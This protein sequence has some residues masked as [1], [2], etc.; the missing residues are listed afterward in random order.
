ML[1]SH[2]LLYPILRATSATWS[3]SICPDLVEAFSNANWIGLC[4]SDV[5]KSPVGVECTGGAEGI[6]QWFQ[7]P[8]TVGLEIVFGTE[9]RDTGAWVDVGR[10][11]WSA[12]LQI[13]SWTAVVGVVIIDE[14]G[15]GSVG[16]DENHL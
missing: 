6:A 15:C 4:A 13:Y 9:D 3:W 8:R 10:R 14:Y 2:T 5:R 1:Q 12:V 11:G 16:W 7:W